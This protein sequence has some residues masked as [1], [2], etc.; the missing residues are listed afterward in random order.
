MNFFDLFRKQPRSVEHCTPAEQRNK[1]ITNFGVA[2][3]ASV[4][5]IRDARI[6]K[7]TKR[8]IYE[9]FT[10]EIRH[11]EQL[12]PYLDE[13]RER[14]N[15]LHSC[16]VHIGDFSDIDPEDASLVHEINFGK[17]FELFRTHHGIEEMKKRDLTVEEQ[18]NHKIFMDMFRKYLARGAEEKRRLGF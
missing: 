17:R 10:E 5:P 16:Y 6:L 4:N 12:A 2:L 11:W 1:I 8:E 3:G 9:A 7:Y 15:W 18:Y 14:L 13:A